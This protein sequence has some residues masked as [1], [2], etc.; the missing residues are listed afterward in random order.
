MCDYKEARVCNVR[1]VGVQGD[2]RT[3]GHP[4]EITLIKPR[5]AD[6][7]LYIKEELDD[8]FQHLSS[9]IANEIGGINRVVILT[10]SDEVP[11]A[12]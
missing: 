10:G 1:T 3:Y 12:F 4:A 6:S 9:R 8:F 2:G 11:I 7:R 5:H